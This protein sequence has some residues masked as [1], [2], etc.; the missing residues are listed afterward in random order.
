MK[1]CA[2]IGCEGGFKSGNVILVTDPAAHT[3][4][5]CNECFE[6]LWALGELEVIGVSEHTKESI[7]AR[8]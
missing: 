3:R 6:E 5:V 8:V 2:T 7:A 1:T 4:E